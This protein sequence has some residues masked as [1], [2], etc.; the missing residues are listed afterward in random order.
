MQKYTNL[1]IKKL[2]N[3][4][5]EIEFQIPFEEIAKNRV[6][7]L[8]HLNEHV[9]LPG[10]R[11]GKIPENIL[12]GRVG[13]MAVLEECVEIVLPKI[14][15]EIIEKEKIETLGRPQISIT[16]LAPE[17]PVE[18]KAKTATM[19]EVKLGD[20]KKIAQKEN[21]KKEEVSEVKDDEVEKIIEQIQKTR[22]KEDGKEPAFD[23]DFVKS[24]GD[25]ENVA[26]F[27]K[28]VKENIKADRERKAKE[29]K[30]MSLAEGVIESSKINMPEILVESELEKM[31]HQLKDDV[32]R[33]SG[34]FED[35][36]KHIKKTEE[37]LKKDWRKDAEKNAKL[38]LILNQIA[39]E[40]KIKAEEKAVEH[41]VKHILEHYPKADPLR[42][43]IYVETILTND[44]VFKFLEEIK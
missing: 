1:K 7:A 40:E 22:P 13:E 29:K 8:K 38:Q 3:S 20:Y 12:V 35:Y 37:D 42:A 11:K 15:T 25:F 10:F 39:V 26:D 6:S 32:S 31:I 5:I 43:R 19:P 30:K 9:E 23:D 4:E 27:K 14:Y 28:K 16:K 18:I 33:T 17:N 21:S 2:P 36:L 41:E 44:A 34:K 24:F